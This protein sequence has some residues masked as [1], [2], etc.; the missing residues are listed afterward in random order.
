MTFDTGK[1]PV[2]LGNPGRRYKEFSVPS[3]VRDFVEGSEPM[4]KI[5]VDQK[6]MVASV[7]TSARDW[8]RKHRLLNTKFSVNQ[9]MP[10]R[11]VY[12]IRAPRAEMEHMLREWGMLRYENPE[13]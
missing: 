11:C 1:F 12:V 6:T 10:Q 13:D 8:L 7:A 9:N 3:V 2:Q 5:T 4:L